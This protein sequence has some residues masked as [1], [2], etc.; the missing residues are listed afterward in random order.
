M[1]I[2]AL[3]TGYA[4]PVDLYAALSRELIDFRTKR[5]AAAGRTH[6]CIGAEW[7]RFMTSFFLPHDDDHLVYVTFGPTGLL[8]AEFDTVLGTS[9][10][11]PNMNDLNMEEHS[12]YVDRGSC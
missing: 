4:A 6:V 1:R 7:H 9:G 11:P 8:P 12:R 2:S 10:T 3:Q 5:G